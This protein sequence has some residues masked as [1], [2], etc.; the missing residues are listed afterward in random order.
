MK[1][2]TALVIVIIWVFV[3]TSIYRFRHPEATDTQ[4][5]LRTPWIITLFDQ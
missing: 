3:T 5:I 4:L 1:L 2:Q